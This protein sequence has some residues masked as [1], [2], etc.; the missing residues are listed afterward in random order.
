MLYWTVTTVVYAV[1]GLLALW[2]ADLWDVWWAIV[3][4]LVAGYVGWMLVWVRAFRPPSD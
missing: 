1:S 2:L 4:A 3:G